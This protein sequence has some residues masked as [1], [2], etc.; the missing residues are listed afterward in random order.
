MVQLGV[1]RILCHGL[2]RK[3]PI[4]RSIAFGYC[5]AA[6][7][8]GCG[9]RPLRCLLICGGGWAP[10]QGF[11]SLL[12]YDDE[13]GDTVDYEVA[14]DGPRGPGMLGFCCARASP[15]QV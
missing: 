2:L 5:D 1:Q 4:L 10:C 12:L 15:I 3:A 13:T 14:L 9:H 8:R 11:I 7:A 6:V